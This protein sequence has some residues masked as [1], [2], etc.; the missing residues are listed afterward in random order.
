MKFT[1]LTSTFTLSNGIGIPCVGFGTWQ[2]E[3]GDEAYGAVLAA[4]R[5]GYRHIDT[6]SAYG[7]EESVGKAIGDFIR[8]GGAERA[9]IFVT[10]KLWND[11]HGYEETKGAISASLEKLGLD[12]ID[13]YLI[14]WP[15]PLK[16]RDC[17]QQRNAGSWR[18]ME[19]AYEAG[20]LRAIG[21]S[22][23]CERH[24]E[25]LA[26]SARI[27]PMVNQIKV[28]PG[29]PQRELA[30]YSRR[31][32]MVVEGYSPLG[33]GK[34]FSSAEMQS[35]AHK[36]GRTIAQICVRWSMQEGCLPLPKSVTESRIVENAG[37]FDF[38]LDK[39][40]CD[41]IAGLTGLEIRPNR[42]PDEAP[43]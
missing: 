10:T 41:L 1:S 25:A 22:N 6:A 27:A 20:L 17:W 12:Y 30:E 8:G 40:D 21:V 29:Q 32:G 37:V 18:A 15:N 42:N 28:C 31:H 16:F 43:F 5:N 26:E 4:L 36:Y 23:F 14:H 34:I 9:E 7:N 19:E 33:T 2:S 35:L 11:D 39:K 24:L 38:E 3:N 13:L